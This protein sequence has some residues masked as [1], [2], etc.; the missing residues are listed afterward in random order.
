M[1]HVPGPHLEPRL[2]LAPR[3][4]QSPRAPSC[5]QPCPMSPSQGGLPGPPVATSP[6][7]L[8]RPL[9]PLTGSSFP[10]CL[11]TRVDARVFASCSSA[12]SP[13]A[14]SSPLLMNGLAEGGGHSEHA[15]LG[16]LFSVQTPGNLWVAGSTPTNEL[17]GRSGVHKQ[18]RA[19]TCRSPSLGR[20][21]PRPGGASLR[22]SAT[23]SCSELPP[24]CKAAPF[25]SAVAVT[26]LVAC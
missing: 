4:L 23:G 25:H 26:G 1:P 16:T 22:G 2:T 13:R 5:A 14:L 7:L 20:P 11:P 8:S 15:G 10:F 18:G 17:Q 19:G 3:A 6:V 12:Q 9:G 21:R 24:L